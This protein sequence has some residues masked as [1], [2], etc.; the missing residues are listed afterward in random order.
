MRAE[1][2]WGY[3]HPRL[4]GTRWRPITLVGP[5]ES[6]KTN[7]AF[8]FTSLILHD[9]GEDKVNIVYAKKFKSAI[10]Y[11]D[12]RPYQ[13]MI[14]DDA[15]RFQYSRFSISREGRLVI[16]DYYE[17]RHVYNK[18]RKKHRDAVLFMIFVTQRWRDL[19]PQFRSAPL[20]LF[21]GTLSNF[22]DNR[23]IEKHLGTEYFNILREITRRIYAFSDDTAKEEGLS[24]I[25]I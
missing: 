18:Y 4:K 11:L 25:H 24:L 17:I 22:H 15:V 16:A 7:A 5:P 13:V 23:D 9:Y 19:A 10:K 12:K 2:I 20:V 6:G 8:F 14:I 21:K 1:D 3:L